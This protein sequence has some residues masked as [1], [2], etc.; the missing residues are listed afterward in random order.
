MGRLNP[1]FVVENKEKLSIKVLI[2]QHRV[3]P[4]YP[5]ETM[6]RYKLKAS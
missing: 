6:K 3:L 5:K 4:R 1:Q 2:K